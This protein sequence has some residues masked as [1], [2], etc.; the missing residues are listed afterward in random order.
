MLACGE[1]NIYWDYQCFLTSLGELVG[2]FNTRETEQ[3][4]WDVVFRDNQYFGWL[5][6]AWVNSR[7]L[8]DSAL[9]GEKVTILHCKSAKEVMQ[10]LTLEFP[11]LD[12]GGDKPSTY[13]YQRRG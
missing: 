5:N 9:S 7:T 11:S 12:G 13:T 2:F 4:F 10:L 1:H 6:K 8:P 3:N